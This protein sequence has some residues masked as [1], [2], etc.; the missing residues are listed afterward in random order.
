MRGLFRSLRLAWRTLSLAARLLV[1]AMLLGGLLASSVLTA[2]LP[3]AFLLATSLAGL[4]VDAGQTVNGRNAR[5]VKELDRQLALSQ[6]D[7]DRL[8]KDLARKQADADALVSENSILKRKLD[9]AGTVIYRGQKRAIKEAVNETSER[10]AERTARAAARNI[11][12]MPGEAIPVYGI[13][14]VVGAT[15]WEVNDAC[16]M[17]GEMYELDVAFNPDHAI[18]DREVCGMR[19]PTAGELWDKMKSAPGEVWLDMKQLLPDL[20]ELRFG[21]RLTALLAWAGGI[22]DWIWTE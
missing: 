7:A 3:S 22:D 21:E 5:K 13:A 11:A 2:V 17:M 9:E 4:V 15:A 16:Q 14:V 19:V 20:P 1:V 8:A 12:A 10:I 18:S 6:V